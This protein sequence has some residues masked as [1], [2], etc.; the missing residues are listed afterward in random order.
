MLLHRLAEKIGDYYVLAVTALIFGLIRLLTLP[1]SSSVRNYLISLSASVPVGTLV[2]ALALELGAPDIASMALTS[3]ASLL[4]H[5]LVLG[6]LNNKG[7]IGALLK[8]AAENLT[9]KVTK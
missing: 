4:A 7:F 9:D 5:D 6:I 1:G 2:G 8:R 3:L